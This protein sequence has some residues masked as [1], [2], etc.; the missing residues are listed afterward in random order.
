ML[1]V[2]A[3]WHE[4]QLH[5]VTNYLIASLAAADCLVGAIVMPFCII[6]EI[7]LGSWTFGPVWCDLYHSFD[8]LAS[9]ASIMNLCAI[10]LDRY[11]AITNPIKY[12]TRM[13]PKRV[14]LLIAFLWTCS[15]LISFPAILWWRAVGQDPLQQIPATSSPPADGS[16]SRISPELLNSGNGAGQGLPVRALTN[17]NNSIGHL[18]W[19]QPLS[20]SLEAQ[21]GPPLPESANLSTSSDGAL[22]R[23]PS[24]SPAT[25]DSVSQVSSSTAASSKSLSFSPFEETDYNSHATQDNNTRYRCVFTDD[26]YYLLF[27]SFIS[28]YG[29]LC[30]MLYAYYRIYKA[31]VKQTRF[32]KHGSKQVMVGK[33]RKAGRNKL[34]G[35]SE[36][37]DSFKGDYSA[38]IEINSSSCQNGP[39][40]SDASNQGHHLVLRAHRGGGGAGGSS[41]K[42]TSG[43]ASNR[44]GPSGSS[45]STTGRVSQT[46]GEQHVMRAPSSLLPLMAMNSD[47]STD[48]LLYCTP[49]QQRAKTEPDKGQVETVIKGGGSDLDESQ[50]PDSVRS[51]PSEAPAANRSNANQILT[52]SSTS[53]SKSGALIPGDLA[54]RETHYNQL[55]S[56]IEEDSKLTRSEQTGGKKLSFKKDPPGTDCETLNSNSYTQRAEQ[57]NGKVAG[58]TNSSEGGIGNGNGIGIGFGQAG[59]RAASSNPGDRAGRSNPAGGNKSLRGQLIYYS[60]EDK[61]LQGAV[62]LTGM[63]Y[64][65]CSPSA[66]SNKQISSGP[67]LGRKLIGCQLA[68]GNLDAI[69]QNNN[70]G[71]ETNDSQKGQESRERVCDNNS[72]TRESILIRSG[73]ESQHR[74]SDRKRS[75]NVACNEPGASAEITNPSLPNPA[76]LGPS[77][78]SLTARSQS[79]SVGRKLTKLA[80]E[81]KAA[82]TLGIVVGVFILCWLPFFLVNIIVAICGTSCIYKPHIVMSIVTW[83]GWLNSAMNP[84]IYACW[85]RDFRRAFRRV[86]CAWVEF[87]CPY[88][89]SNIARKLNLK[90]SSNYSPQEV[91]LNRAMSSIKGNT[92]TATMRSAVGPSTSNS[93]GCGAGP[94]LANGALGVCQPAR[95][96]EGK[97]GCEDMLATGTSVAGSLACIEAT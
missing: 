5:S 75:E 91:Y 27:S 8:V 47:T 33:R 80:K 29:P 45:R 24:L 19:S 7:I 1:V 49:S 89:G 16:T 82:K 46:A 40:T 63:H 97:Q 60:D 85:S 53:A 23:V 94:L 61:L 64:I 77:S 30:V 32:L 56:S 93:I 3:I 50:Q 39:S 38:R 51:H 26:T 69:D 81:R 52:S 72:F 68:G 37:Q 31:A 96:L 79:R 2:S 84:V 65:D 13:T 36:E 43:P 20:V 59:P 4:N 54:T 35:L 87:V 14:A 78:G 22:A 41:I 10:S 83:L 18:D 67:E 15:S 9:T 42:L 17:L 86:L 62:D 48:S 71:S 88:E 55:A 74:A 92:S 12:P 95:D 73:R 25:P 21:N 76:E 90:K 28:F 6:S 11:I 57:S 66:S 58:A 70:N 34:K 44:N